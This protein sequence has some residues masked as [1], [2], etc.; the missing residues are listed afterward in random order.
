MTAH[1]QSI[2]HAGGLQRK[3]RSSMWDRVI[4]RHITRLEGSAPIKALDL[5]LDKF[6]IKQSWE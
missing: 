4:D 5:I 1:P 2:D 3:V 6:G